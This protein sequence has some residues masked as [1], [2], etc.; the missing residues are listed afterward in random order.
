MGAVGP[1]NESCGMASDS[2]GTTDPFPPTNDTWTIV[3]VTEPNSLVGAL[4]RWSTAASIALAW[5][6]AP[7]TNDIHRY[8]IQFT[9][10]G[11]AWTDLPGYVDTPARSAMFTGTDGHTYAFRSIATD[12][13]G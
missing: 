12:Y 7:G 5:G 2:E 13:A 3:D 6:P 4:P 10:N 11:G 1:A 8:T 9:D